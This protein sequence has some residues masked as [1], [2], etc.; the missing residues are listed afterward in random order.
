MPEESNFHRRTSFRANDLV[1]QAN[2]DPANRPGLFL[3]S[4]THQNVPFADGAGHS[5]IGGIEVSSIRR[6]IL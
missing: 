5:C 1:R 6:D 4:L 3:D 2:N